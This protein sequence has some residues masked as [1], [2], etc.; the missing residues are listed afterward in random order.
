[1]SKDRRRPDAARRGDAD[2]DVTPPG[3][4]ADTVVMDDLSLA[5]I[6][7]R[8]DNSV[9]V[10]PEMLDAVVAA[11]EG[12]HARLRTAGLAP[13]RWVKLGPTSA[14]GG[15]D[16]TALVYDASRWRVE[17]DDG[18]LV[19]SNLGPRLTDAIRLRT[20]VHGRVVDEGRVSVSGSV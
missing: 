5:R 14:I 3:W 8:S 2:R 12:G 18:E 16:D 13:K 1:V 11:D 17:E 15:P 7:L 9:G 6:E 10:A 4:I 20:G 19:I